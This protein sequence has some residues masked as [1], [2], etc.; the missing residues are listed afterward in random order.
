MGR[1]KQNTGDRTRINFSGL[2]SENVI[3]SVL[4]FLFSQAS[5]LTYT[6]P[7]GLAFFASSFSSTGWIYSLLGSV[8]GIII[9]RGDMTFLRYLLSLCVTASILGI[10]EKKKN[11]FFRA[12]VIS[13]IY[14]LI[15]VIFM[16]MERFVMYDFMLL[17]LE[18]FVCFFSVYLINDIIAVSKN[19]RLRSFFT[20]GEITSIFTLTSIFILSLG[21]M[22]EVFG[23]KPASVFVIFLMMNIA[24]YTN[25]SVSSLSGVV[26]GLALSMTEHYSTSVIGAYAFCGFM[27]SLF[28]RYSR[29][30]VVLGFSL[31]NAIITAFLND[32]FYVILNPLEVFFTGVLFV[33]IPHK[34]HDISRDFFNKILNVGA[35][36]GT[37][38]YYISKHRV[39]KVSENINHIASV[40]ENDCKKVNV[41]KEYLM[42]LFDYACDNVC[43]YCG[44]KFGCWKNNGNKNYALMMSLFD[45]IH[46][47]G[48]LSVVDL[49]KNFSERCVKKEEFVKV[50]NLVYEIYRTDK[51]W[52]DK[53]NETKSLM[54]NQMHGVAQAIENASGDFEVTSDTPKEEYLRS[55]LETEGFF[56]AD[57]KVFASDCDVYCVYLEFLNRD[58]ETDIEKICHIVSDSVEV[59]VRYNDTIGTERGFISC[60]YPREEYTLL[61]AVA[62]ECKDGECVNGDFTGEVFLPQ[63]Y[64]YVMLSDGMGSGEKAH[65]RSSDTVKMMNS[66]LNAGF[67]FPSAVKL[68]NSS[69]LLNFSKDS[70][71]TLDILGVNLFT[72]EICISKTGSAPTY[73]KM[74][75]DVKKIES[76]SLPVGIL[77][78]IEFEPV[79][80]H[81]DDDY[82]VVVM[83]SDGVSNTFF[84]NTC[85]KDWVE[86]ELKN[87]S[88]KNVQLVANKIL[89]KALAKYNDKAEDDITVT[90]SIIYKN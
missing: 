7:F 80:F 26:F 29:L 78:E 20:T 89:K 67:D 60:F 77:R 58:F 18:S 53:M 81:A 4:C 5:V 62:S 36:A 69:L 45:K 14:F 82:T 47:S 33:G 55:A 31:T 73:I 12:S 51:L 63:G 71:A 66:F 54:A 46:K 27:A 52:M 22:P 88:S 70:F 90:V 11:I 24:L 64:G 85:E 83:I 9:S 56:C 59:P 8:L 44:L 42:K 86:D 61:T 1:T 16:N 74:G 25:I 21:N 43:A 19:F 84:D 40:Y 57:V 75:K 68:L 30:G 65:K 39:G 79:V 87:I 28:R 41:S 72:G 37:D 35:I 34:F 15:G 48:H 2:N 49:P 10:F 50:V 13:V 23:F 6:N 76:T 38:S 17:L 32:T 3:I